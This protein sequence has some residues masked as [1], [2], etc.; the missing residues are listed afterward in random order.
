MK[1]KNLSEIQLEIEI[2]NPYEHIMP[3]A[4]GG[5]T[6]AHNL[7]LLCANHNALTAL[8]TYGDKKMKQYWKAP[9]S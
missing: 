1:F 7:R 6:K 4:L 3:F 2:Q 9:L 8:I 5:E